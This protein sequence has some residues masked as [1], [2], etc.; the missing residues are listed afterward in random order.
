MDGGES[1]GDDECSEGGGEKRK[2][3]TIYISLPIDGDSD[4]TT[5]TIEAFPDW[6]ERGRMEE[7]KRRRF[8]DQDDARKGKR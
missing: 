3:T 7:G 1:D 5:R 6:R 8:S 4:K 2:K